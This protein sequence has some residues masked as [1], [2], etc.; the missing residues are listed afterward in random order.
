[1]ETEILAFIFIMLGALIQTVLQFCL[2]IQQLPEGQEI[3]FNPQYWATMIVSILVAFMA[4]L[5]IFAGFP[6]PTG[7]P[8]LYVVVSAL[9]AG[10][11][12]SVTT[13]LSL[14]T[15]QATKANTDG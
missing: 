4:A 3:K 13:N 15:Y 1:M 2:K 11:S 12:V 10:F 9:T 14:N 5:G 7:V 6:I 8:V